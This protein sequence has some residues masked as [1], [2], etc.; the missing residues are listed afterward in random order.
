MPTAQSLIKKVAKVIQKVGP[1]ARTSYKRVTVM[2]GG[3]SLIGAAGTSTNYD[4]AFDPQPVFHQLSHRQAM[5][6]SNATLQLVADDYSFT[7]PASTVS[8]NDFEDPRVSLVLVDPTNGEEL[9]KILYIDSAQ[10]QGADVALTIF[11]RSIG[12]NSVSSL[13]IATPSGSPN[14]T[15][16]EYIDTQLTA[17]DAAEF[18]GDDGTF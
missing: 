13:N 7:F 10:Y 5:Y 1:M 8:K 3:D 11:A 4:T 12:F 16:Q 14:Q 2:S 15:V 17:E 9:L 18:D 6:L